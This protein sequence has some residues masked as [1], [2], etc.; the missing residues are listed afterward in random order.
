MANQLKTANIL[1]VNELDSSR[2]ILVSVLKILGVASI[3]EAYEKTDAFRKFKD[4]KY[5]VVMAGLIGGVQDVIG[6]TQLIR[7][8]ASSPNPVVPVV[9][10]T[11]P[12]SMH[13]VDRARESGITDLLQSPFTVDDVSTRLNFVSSLAQEALENDTP[14]AKPMIENAAENAKDWPDEEE[15]LSLTD[16]LLD[17]YMKHHEIVLAKLKFAQDATKKSIDEIRSTHEKVREHDN[18]NIHAFTDFNKMWEEIIKMFVDGGLST[19][20]LFKIEKV[21]TTVPEDI[22]K[23]YDALSSQDKSFLALVESLNVDAY[24]KAKAK[25]AQ[26]QQLPNPLH[27]K[28]PED[29]KTAEESE[30][31][32]PDAFIFMPTQRT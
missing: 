25:V 32:N 8:D 9:A 18:T 26:L 30:Q 15:A 17:H 4:K 21:I 16:M 19:D 3:D 20:E 27:G 28:I 23:H 14:Y 5:D 31:E 11:G 7:N 22:K 12:K 6:L 24:K 13:L 29:Y 1:V 10:V 2:K